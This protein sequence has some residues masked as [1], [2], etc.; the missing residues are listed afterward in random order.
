MLTLLVWRLRPARVLAVAG[1]ALVVLCSAETTH[2]LWKVVHGNSSG[3]GLGGGSLHDADWVDRAVP[4]G[5][6]AEQWVDNLGGLD[7]ARLLWEGETLWNRS[8]VGAYTVDGFGDPFL[9]TTALVVNSRSGAINTASGAPQAR[10][11][12]LP[13]AASRSCRRARAR[14]L[15]EPKARVVAGGDADA[16][17]LGGLRGLAGRLAR[18]Y[19]PATVRLYA[20]RGAA[21]RCATVGSRCR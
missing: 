15:A 16:R 17:R 20:L 2:A 10:Y 13:R 1:V 4:A 21:G 5:A 18:L 14:A 7:T 11:V 8:I 19:K 3:A 6:S 9:P 12:A